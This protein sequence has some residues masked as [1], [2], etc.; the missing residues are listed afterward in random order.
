MFRDNKLKYNF[1]QISVTIINFNNLFHSFVSLTSSLIQ[2]NLYLSF[3]C[4]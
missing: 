1:Q 2:L 3:L 4:T